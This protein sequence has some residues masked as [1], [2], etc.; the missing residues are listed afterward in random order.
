M[1]VLRLIKWLQLQNLSKFLGS[2]YTWIFLGSIYTKVIYTSII[3]YWLFNV[4]LANGQSC[5]KKLGKFLDTVV[6]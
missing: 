3:Y 6:C 5:K 2:L 4:G 1:L